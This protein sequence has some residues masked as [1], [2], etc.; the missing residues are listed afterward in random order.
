[1]KFRNEVILIASIDI[2]ILSLVFLLMNIFNEPIF[3]LGL[4]FIPL[5]WLSMFYLGDKDSDEN[6][7]LFCSKCNKK[8]SFIPIG[9]KGSN[10][11]HKCLE[12]NQE[13]YFEYD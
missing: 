5:S 3:S 8:T 10:R 2:L 4:F 7:I 9:F 1:M 11:R 6:K 12:C 13:D